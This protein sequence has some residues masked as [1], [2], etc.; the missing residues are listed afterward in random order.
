VRGDAS[1]PDC[2]SAGLAISNP[3][4]QA[5]SNTTVNP[6]IRLSIRPAVLA[7]GD[8]ICDL[9][10][11]E[12]SAEP[13]D[14]AAEA[15]TLARPIA[16]VGIACV[17]IDRLLKTASA[18]VLIRTIVRCDCANCKDTLPMPPIQNR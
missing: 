5:L 2:A 7:T 9:P 8:E 10:I 6:R 14:E 17:T 16:P 11:N 4:S 18:S 13:P 15:L 12:S 3:L 1:E